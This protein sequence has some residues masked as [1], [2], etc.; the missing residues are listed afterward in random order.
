MVPS[1]A[2]RFRHVVVLFAG[3]GALAAPALAQ[4]LSPAATQASA[5]SGEEQSLVLEATEENLTPSER[6]R[7]EPR[8]V[9]TGPVIDGRLDEEVWLEAAVID[10]F[11]QQEPSEG[12]PATERTVVRLLYD[13]R[14]LYIGVEAYDSE[15]GGVQRHLLGHRFQDGH[16]GHAARPAVQRLLRTHGHLR[17]PP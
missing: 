17:R 11:I 14:S 15:P 6:Y 10:E 12:D 3:F 5:P 4:P 16:L 2:R 1:Y 8:R 13:A 7:V 9:E